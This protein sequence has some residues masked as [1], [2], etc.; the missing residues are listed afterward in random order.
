MFICSKCQKENDEKSVYCCNC[1]NPLNLP[2]ER[3]KYFYGELLSWEDL[4]DEQGYFNEKR[5]RLNEKIRALQILDSIGELFNSDG[6][7]IIGF[8][9]T[10]SG[11][12]MTMAAEFIAYELKFGIYKIDISLV[13]SKYIEETEKN[14]KKVFEDAESSGSLLFLDEADTL[15]GKRSEVEDAHDR[16]QQ[17]LLEIIERFRGIAI[18]ASDSSEEIDPVFLRKM[19]FSINFPLSDEESV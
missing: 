11:K 16:Y 3:D 6:N 7:L 17:Y 1:G 10:H 2:F 5:K 14:L 4:R 12:E 18:L 19:R 9:G 8:F 13:V 15:F